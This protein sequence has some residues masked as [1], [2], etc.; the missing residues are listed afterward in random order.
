MNYVAFISIV[1]L[2][3]LMPESGKTNTVQTLRLLLPD[4]FT[5][6]FPTIFWSKT[7]VLLCSMYLFDGTLGA[8]S[9]GLTY[10]KILVRISSGKW[11]LRAIRC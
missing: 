5:G 8:D 2:M 11:H 10:T 1:V 3:M 6:P 9:F 7:A 4:Q